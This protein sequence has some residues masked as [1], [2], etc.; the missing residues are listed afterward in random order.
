MVL[1]LWRR[2]GFSDL[3]VVVALVLAEASVD[4]VFS[5]S[6]LVGELEHPLGAGNPLPPDFMHELLILDPGHESIDDIVLGDVVKL[7]LPSGEASDVVAQGYALL[8]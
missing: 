3:F 8:A 1:P 4:S 7:V 2:G 6:E 5:I